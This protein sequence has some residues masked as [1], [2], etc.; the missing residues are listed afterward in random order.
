MITVITHGTKT[1]RVVCPICNCEFTYQ[2]EDLNKD[3]FHNHYVICPDCGI[4][5]PHEE[6]KNR[7][8]NRDILC[9]DANDTTD[10]SDIS[11]ITLKAKSA[12]RS[13]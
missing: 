12:S 6:Q 11:V 13:K 3:V 10:K 5:I 7:A 9:D 4:H 8:F 1:F 2:E